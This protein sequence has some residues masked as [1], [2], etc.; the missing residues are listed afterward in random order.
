MITKSSMRGQFK[1]ENMITKSSRLGQF[2]G[3]NMITKQN[4]KAQEEMVGFALI[5]IIVAVIILILLGISLNKPEV[6]SGIE[7]YETD[8]FVQAL[9]QHTT[10]CSTD[11]GYSYN[12]F[13]SLVSECD[14]ELFCWNEASKEQ[15]IPACDILDS[16]AKNIMENSWKIGQDRPIK[17]YYL[18]ITQ[19]NIEILTLS[20]GNQTVNYK[21]SISVLVKKG[22]SYNL[23]FRAYY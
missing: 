21:G 23:D 1:G 20:A 4:K 19:N 5:I 14:R 18:N 9:F 8:S 13:A 6:S 11:Y 2:K 15:D 10:T 22:S 3:E 7:S 12:D 17:G 16:T